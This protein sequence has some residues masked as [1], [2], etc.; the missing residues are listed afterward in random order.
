MQDTATKSVVQPAAHAT[1][2]F[3]P[4][5]WLSLLIALILAPNAIRAQ[6]A[7]TANLQGTV[8]DPTG[9]VISSATVDLIDEN[10]TVKRETHTDG[11]GIYI[12]PDIPAGTYDLTVNSPGGAS[13]TSAA[14]QFTVSAAVATPSMPLGMVLLLAVLVGLTGMAFKAGRLL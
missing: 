2:W 9:A 10:T 4:L 8:A 7:G 13:A 1:R 12:F 6:I 3:E 5:V 14:D 11:S